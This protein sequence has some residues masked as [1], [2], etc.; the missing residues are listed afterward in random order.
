MKGM[1]SFHPKIESFLE[2]TMGPKEQAE[3]EKELEGQP[4]LQE[5]IKQ[6]KIAQ[7]I[8]KVRRHMDLRQEIDTIALRQSLNPSSSHP[9]RRI[10]IAASLAILF[11]T[12]M[13]YFSV[14]SR[15]SN[16]ALFHSFFDPYPIMS[17][18]IRGDQDSSNLSFNQAMNAYGNRDFH[19]SADLLSSI[20]DQHPGINI[21]LANSLLA[22]NESQEAVDVLL[23]ERNQSNYTYTPVLEWYLALAYLKLGLEDSAI[24]I[25]Y[26]LKDQKVDKHYQKKANSSLKKI[27]SKYR[28]IPGIQ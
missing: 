14:Q 27:E 5:Q 24:H 26:S 2:G 17:G 23:G 12:T 6:Y 15:L 21:Y 18:Q 7:R 28:Q 3:F 20:H 19:S 16:K 11:C 25:L 10:L 9:Y 22:I 8:L 1:E 4:E 13:A